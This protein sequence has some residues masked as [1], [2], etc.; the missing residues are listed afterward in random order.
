MLG[1]IR[2]TDFGYVITWP[3]SEGSEV[4]WTTPEQVQDGKFNITVLLPELADQYET[5]LVGRPAINY[6]VEGCHVVISKDNGM[7]DEGYT[8][9]NGNFVSDTLSYGTYHIALTYEWEETNMYGTRSPPVF[10]CYDT[11]ELNEPVEN[12]TYVL[13]ERPIVEFEE[14]DEYTWYMQEDGIS[15]EILLVRYGST[16]GEL[17]VDINYYTEDFTLGED[18]TFT[19]RVTFDSGELFASLMVD[20][21]PYEYEDGQRT[22]EFYIV[23]SN[24]YTIG[25]YDMFTANIK[26]QPV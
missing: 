18:F 16:D 8:D 26:N 4:H 7:V 2:P 21:D 22:I 17:T 12:R 20:I 15:L 23:E 19:D 9:E 3:P 13:H 10:V 1:E 24:D 14:I 25:F 5:S 11:T 6:P